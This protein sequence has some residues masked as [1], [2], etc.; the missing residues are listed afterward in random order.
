MANQFRKLAGR[1]T[2]S[3]SLAAGVVVLA[4][5]L[6]VVRAPLAGA[7]VAGGL[8]AVVNWALWRP[9]RHASSCE[10]KDGETVDSGQLLK[11]LAIAAVIAV[12]AF[13]LF[14]LVV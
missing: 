1:Y 4:L 13:L 9:R 14:V 11:T 6:V 8:T 5:A 3:Y 12:S 2:L 7:A 10:R